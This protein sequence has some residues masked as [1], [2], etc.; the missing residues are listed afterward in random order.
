MLH[1]S[2]S[3][4]QYL[5]Q[6]VFLC[7]TPN[8]GALNASICQG[9]FLCVTP[10]SGGGTGA[11]HKEVTRLRKQNQQL[12]EENNLLKLKLD[13]LLDMVSWSSL[14]RDSMT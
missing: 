5:S 3:K 8:F 13:I 2:S 12:Q 7:V 1:L 4:C 14:S 9:V 10:E 6:D 11:S